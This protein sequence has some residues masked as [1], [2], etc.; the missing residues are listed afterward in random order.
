MKQQIQHLIE[1]SIKKLQSLGKLSKDI[2]PQVRV[3]RTRA[4]E[5]GDFASNIAMA[6]AET[7]GYKPRELAQLIIDYLPSSKKIGT[8]TIAGPGFINFY[9]TEE[10][11]RD[12]LADILELKNNYGCSDLGKDKRINIEFVSANPTGPLH[13]GHGRSAAYGD[14]VAS[15]LEA[16]GYQVDREYYVNDLGRQ[17]HILTVSIWLRYLSL[18]TDLPHFPANGYKGNYILDIAKQLQT[19][20]G[21]QFKCP[22]EKI[23]AKLPKD[24]DQSG[25]SEVYMDALIARNKALLG[26]RDYSVIFEMGLRTILND[27]KQ[28]LSEFGVT[29]QNWFFESSL[30][31]DKY[32]QKCIDELRHKGHIYEKDGA[33]WFRATGFG[34]E[35]DR[36]V[37]RENG[38]TTYFASDIAYHFNKY[39]RAYD[40]IIDIFGSDH[41]GYAP[42]IRA[43]LKAAELDLNEFHV[44]LVQFAIL[45]RGKQR[46]QMSTRGGEFVTLRELREEVGNDVARF[47]YI[48]RKNDQH[49]D[50]DLDLAKEQSINNPVYYIQYAHARICS[51]MHQLREKKLSWDQLQGLSNL[52]L[53][54]EAEEEKLLRTLHDYKSI[55]QDAAQR[56]EPHLLA[57]YLQE[58]ADDFHAYYN[59]H[60]FLVE[61]QKLRDARLCL[62]MAVKQIFVNG[63]TLLK[64]SVPETM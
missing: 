13:V 1:S 20:Y 12:V 17:M 43:F 62:I 19:D 55:L 63:L 45:Y 48:M 15:L 2:K 28:D 42:R 31:I 41:H 52:D 25:N 10:T 64:I 40:Q 34:D 39:Q 38:Q 49:L 60:Q 3:E 29:F 9:L 47:F 16:M 54:R 36:V 59:A 32:I 11:L 44:L 23:F 56:Y 26:E 51:V 21:D 14:A 5:Y 37:V 24:A 50:F 7:T 27:I 6:L 46:V 4:K 8:I 30:I 53:L 57:H 35:K 22:L 33:L 18:F 58:L 61:K